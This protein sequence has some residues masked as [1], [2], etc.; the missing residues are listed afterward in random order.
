MI[1]TLDNDALQ[2]N[3]ENE[4]YLFDND[5]QLIDNDTH[6]IDNDTHL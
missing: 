6:L 3:N 2:I 5:T 1:H 4:T